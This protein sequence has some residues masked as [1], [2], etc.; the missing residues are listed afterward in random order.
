VRIAGVDHVL[1]EKDSEKRVLLKDLDKVM[2][3][4]QEKGFCQPRNENESLPD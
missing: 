3:D 4:G 1:N 2:A